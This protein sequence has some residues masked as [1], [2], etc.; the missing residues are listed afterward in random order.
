MNLI[1]SIR[2]D[3]QNL[4]RSSP[5]VLATFFKTGPGDYAEHDQFMGLRTSLLRLC[6]KRFYHASELDLVDLLTSPINEER[7]L[8]LIIMTERY[9][10]EPDNIYSLYTCHIRHVNNWNLVDASAH[11]IAG[12]HAWRQN[13]FDMLSELVVSPSIWERRIA[14]VATWYAIKKGS[15]QWTTN[16]AEQLLGDSHDLIHKATGWMLREMGKKNLPALLL[17]LDKYAAHMPRTMLRYAIEKLP[18]E[19]KQFYMKA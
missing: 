7:L 2:E 16:I 18:T 5:P 15:E 12:A 13:K 19:Q 3:L 14:I 17:F 4:A 10:Y 11:L 1:V 8:S 9:Q 6:A